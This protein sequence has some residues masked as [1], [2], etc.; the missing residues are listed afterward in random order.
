MQKYGLLGFPLGHSFSKKYFTNKFDI[1]AI[2]AV[3][4]NYEIENID[5]IR[6]IVVDTKLVGL[7][8]TIP[9]KEAVIALLDKLSDEARAIGAVNVI[10]IERADSGEI[11]LIGHNSDVIGFR[12][13]I[14][15][16]IREDQRNA[17]ILGT[18][19]AS[20]AVA[21]ALTNMGITYKYVS[22]KGSGDV[23]SYVDLTKDIIESHTIII[24]STPLGTYPKIDSCPDIPY[25]HITSEH[26]LYD[27]VYNPEETLF[28]K[29]G[30]ERGAR[31]KNGEEMLILQ[32]NAAWDIWQE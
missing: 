2:D 12:K 19:G 9:H 13:S 29:R 18:G 31:I 30:K 3:Y 11:E 32:A 21:R 16:L 14:E 6:S 22:R 1:E 23:L 8:V 24:N 20:K 26:L 25:Q 17:L 4:D 15:P 10:K 27:L 7:N 28:L 5:E